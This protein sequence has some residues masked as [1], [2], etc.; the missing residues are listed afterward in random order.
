MDLLLLLLSPLHPLNLLISAWFPFY[1]PQNTSQLLLASV[2]QKK[3]GIIIITIRSVAPV[4]H[5][6]LL[7]SCYLLLRFCLLHSSSSCSGVVK[8]WRGEELGIASITVIS[9]ILLFW[10][11]IMT[12]IIVWTD[13]FLLLLSIS[14]ARPSFFLL[15]AVALFHSCLSLNE[16]LIQRLTRSY[17]RIFVRILHLFFFIRKISP[18]PLLLSFFDISHP[19][20]WRRG[21]GEVGSSN[22]LD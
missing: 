9:I 12:V 6:L 2:T 1:F 5:L 8:A 22:F 4:V 3:N 14:D 11:I 20:A 21:G 17:R 10:M 15:K 13:V 16:S 18:P 7:S 19:F